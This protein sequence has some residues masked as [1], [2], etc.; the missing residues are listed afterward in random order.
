MVVSQAQIEQKG[1]KR[2]E[3]FGFV[4]QGLQYGLL[5]WS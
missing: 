3:I 4:S 1:E 2:N 5:L